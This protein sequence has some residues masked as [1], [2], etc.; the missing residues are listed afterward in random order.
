MLSKI[1]R[2][3][4]ILTSLILITGCAVEDTNNTTTNETTECGYKYT[5]SC[6][7]DAMSGKVKCGTGYYYVCY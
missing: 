5:Y 1:K 6:G 2:I 7:F 4:I 3:I